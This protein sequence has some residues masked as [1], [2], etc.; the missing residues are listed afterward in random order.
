MDRIVVSIKINT[1]VGERAVFNAVSNFCRDNLQK[2]EFSVSGKRET[3]NG[4]I[5]IEK[6][7]EDAE[8]RRKLEIEKKR[9]EE[10]EKAKTQTQIKTE[11]KSLIEPE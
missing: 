10:E 9:F 4:L 3:L 8:R 2:C 7:K 6:E 1:K 11:R 5:D